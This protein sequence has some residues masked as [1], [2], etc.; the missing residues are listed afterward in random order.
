MK[1]NELKY[2]VLM[3]VYYKE[4]PEF[5]D[6]SINCMLN[7]TIKP[8]EFVIVKDGPLTNEL[9]NVIEKYE[10]LHK[11]IFKII[12]LEKNIGLGL[13]LNRGILECSN[14]LIARMDSDDYSPRDRIQKQLNILKENPSLSIIGSNAVEFCDSISDIVSYVKLPKNP[15]EVYKFSKRRCPFRHSGILYKKTEV[16]KAGNYQ[17]CYLCEDYD[18]YA[19][20][21]MNGSKGYNIQEDLLYVRVNR[22]FYK[23]R[24]GLKYLNSILKFKKKLYQSK[25]YSK[26]DYIISSGSHIVVTMVPN[27]M[28]NFIYKKFLRSEKPL[29]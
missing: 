8:N 16:L 27:F 19:R 22:D 7:Q 3:S 28:R 12:S 15:E 13:A 14:E 17:D 10:K 24:G 25:F 6:Y 18:L 9:D 29:K 5:L 2:S 1:K 11:D 20:M 21:L 26:K 4:K 23:R